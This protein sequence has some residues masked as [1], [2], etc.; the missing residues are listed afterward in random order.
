MVNKA[1][2]LLALFEAEDVNCIHIQKID[3]GCS[4]RL[5]RVQELNGQSSTQDHKACIKGAGAIEVDED[6][7]EIALDL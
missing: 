4:G 6:Q 2:V 7:N 5:T 1:E 3:S